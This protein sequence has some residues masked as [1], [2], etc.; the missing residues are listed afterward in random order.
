[1]ARNVGR[2]VEV[3]F[4]GN[5]TEEEFT[6]WT[7]ACETCLRECHARTGKPE[8]CLTDLRSSRL[9]SPAVTDRLIAVM[10]VD[11]RALDRNALLATG[12]ATFTMQLQRLVRESY[13]GESRRRVFT[14][15]DPSLVWLDEILTPAERTRLREF[16]RE[17]CEDPS[18]WQS[19]GG[20]FLWRSDAPA[21]AAA[22]G[23]TPS[24]RAGRASKPEAAEAGSRGAEDKAGP[25]RGTSDPPP[26]KANLRPIKGGRQ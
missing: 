23:S 21:V 26:P 17:D 5:P 11:N 14:E 7:R 12:G 24:A 20:F 19:E 10:R 15:V 6:S 8:V 25:T 4:A 13:S 2:L 1:M 18:S 16:M 22:R 9:F 3:R